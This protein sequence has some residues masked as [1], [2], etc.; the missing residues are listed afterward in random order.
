MKEVKAYKDD[1]HGIRCELVDT[2]MPSPKADQVLI[3]VIVSGTNPKDWKIPVLM[4]NFDGSNSG[5]DIAGYIHSVGGDVTEFHKGD[6]V[7]AFHQ[8]VTDNG[9]FSPHPRKSF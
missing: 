9:P 7:A 2:A 6:R 4:P 1:S 8:M 5:D 3:K